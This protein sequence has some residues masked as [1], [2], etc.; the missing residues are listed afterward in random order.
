MPAVIN[1]GIIS[2]VLVRALYYFRDGQL[3]RSFH[4]GLGM[5][6]S[7]TK[8]KWINAAGKIQDY[9][10]REVSDLVC[11]ALDTEGVGNGE[12]G[13]YDHYACRPWRPAR[14]ICNQDLHTGDSDPRNDQSVFGISIQK[15]WLRK[16]LGRK[17]GKVFSES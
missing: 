6:T 10:E 9:C 3:V 16:R 15:S 8:T 1:S 17:H 14:Q 7:K 13:G 4:V 12:A 11:P 5:R 2:T